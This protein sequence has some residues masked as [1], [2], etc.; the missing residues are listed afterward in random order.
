MAI[1]LGLSAAA[2][3]PA[4]IGD[5]ALSNATGTTLTVTFTPVVRNVTSYQE[6]HALNGTGNWS[7]PATI[8]SGGTITGLDASTNYDAQVRAVGPIGNGEWSNT[9]T[10]ATT[11]GTLPGTQSAPTIA[12]VSSSALSVTFS[13][14]SNAVSHQERHA[15][16][17]PHSTAN[18]STGWWSE[19]ATI[20]TGSNIT[21]LDPLIE[22]EVQ[23]RG[24]NAV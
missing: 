8:L 17:I 10:E 5:C 16:K 22:Y 11:G 21:G 24:V 14:A 6:R 19:P 15:P 3:L 1:I 7:S 20:T 12:Q 18:V 4:T 23:T 2:S 13:A 9:D